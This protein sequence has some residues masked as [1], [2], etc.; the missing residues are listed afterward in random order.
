MEYNISMDIDDKFVETY[1]ALINK[2]LTKAG[3]HGELREEIKCRIYER[4]LASESYD[5]SRGKLST[6][7]WQI[8][9]SVISN[10]VKRHDRSQ[11]VLDHQ[12]LLTLEEASNII[13]AEDAGAAEDAVSKLTKAAGVSERDADIVLA[14]YGHEKPYQQVADEFDMGLEAVKKVAYRTM[15]ALRIQ[16][17]A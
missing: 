13:G 15:K 4:V 17:E 9:R 5:A 7:L 2:R 14:I 3:L 12:P 6:W 11:D 8:C 1:D 10:E 16:A